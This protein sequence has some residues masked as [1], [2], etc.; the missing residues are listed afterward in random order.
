MLFSGD[1]F[2]DYFRGCSPF[3][4]HNGNSFGKH[5]ERT[6]LDGFE[7]ENCKELCF[8]PNCNFVATAKKPMCHVC[9]VTIDSEGNTVGASDPQCLTDLTDSR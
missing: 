8:G 6:V 7:H 2:E 9:S 1:Y 4:E 3:S 5:C